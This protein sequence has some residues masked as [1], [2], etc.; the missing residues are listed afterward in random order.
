MENKKSKL[1][2]TCPDP[3]T[4]EDYMKRIAKEGK[5]DTSPIRAGENVIAVASTLIPVPEY[6]MSL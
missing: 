4:V 1:S 3:G 2:F 5:F 6:K